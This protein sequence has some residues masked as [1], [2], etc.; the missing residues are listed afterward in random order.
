MPPSRKRSIKSSSPPFSKEIV[1]KPKQ[2]SSKKT[3]KNE[4]L[5]P[6]VSSITDEYVDEYPDVEQK[7]LN[8]RK[9]KEKI[10]ELNSWEDNTLF[11]FLG[12]AISVDEARRRWPFRYE[13]CDYQEEGWQKEEEEEVMI[14]RRHFSQAL[15]HGCVY[16]LYDHVHVQ[17]EGD[18]LYIARIV[19]FFE[20]TDNKAYFTAQWFYKPADTVIELK[21]ISKDLQNVFDKRRIGLSD[22]QCDYFC[23][24][25]YSSSFSTFSNLP[26]DF[27]TS[28]QVQI[29]VSSKSSNGCGSAPV[30][31][32]NQSSMN[33][34]DLYAGCGAMSTGLCLGAAKSGLKLITR[35]AVDYNQYACSSLKLNHPDTEV[36][37]ESAEDFLAL[38]QAWQ[39]LCGQF[40]LL[41]TP[42][43]AAENVEST[44]FEEGDDEEVPEGEFEV[45]KFI[46]ICF[47]DPRKAE[48]PGLHY[49]GDVDVLCG[50][51]PCQGI[52]GFNRFR[53]KENPLKDLKNKQ[54]IIFMN[55]VDFLKPRFILMENVLDILKFAGG[56]L[57]RY[58]LGRLVGM[59]YQVRLGVMAAGSYG[60]PQFRLRA[61][62]WGACCNEGAN[63]RD[64]PG[65]VFDEKN[66]VA[67]DPTV[68][69]ELLPSRKPLVP[70]YAIKFVR[71][72]SRKPFGRVWFDETI[73]TV[74]TRAEPHNQAVLHPLEDRVLTIRENARIQGFPDY[75]RLSGP[76]KQR[77]LDGSVGTF[78][79]VGSRVGRVFSVYQIACLGY[80]GWYMQVGNAVAVPVACA[81]GYA[82][83]EACKGTLDDRPIVALPKN[84]PN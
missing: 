5:S 37:N 22:E 7:I 74:V 4:D 70:D 33:L 56:Y 15:V 16:N 48:E 30:Q 24:M 73:A 8:K 64:L 83:G 2:S 11:R 32:N 41:G 18:T 44:D 77:A 47:G 36:R 21:V 59:N 46:G 38:L 54:L 78:C 31:K 27:L 43:S 82:L 20:A 79:C 6:N 17:G 76:V 75:Y 1:K 57:G 61:F 66:K 84:F 72:I 42:R 65:L 53:D 50:G 60:L 81:L 26:P 71:G 63:F 34:L 35:W 40:S 51:P 49:K 3:V 13:V 39:Q 58:T 45:E 19:E 55:T 68:K 28:P 52:S 80:V 62:F 14:A 25:H 23:D 69:R 67:L 9:K 29:G 12:E 10:T